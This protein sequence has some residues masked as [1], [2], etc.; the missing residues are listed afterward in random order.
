MT[1][2][3]TLAS[4]ENKVF[5]R[6]ATIRKLTATEQLNMENDWTEYLQN[7]VNFGNKHYLEFFT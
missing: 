4:L 3:G 2:N 5:R 6:A 1:D 7:L